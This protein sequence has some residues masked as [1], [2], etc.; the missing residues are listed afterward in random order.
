MGRAGCGG[1]SANKLVGKVVD[2]VG[3]E[4]NKVE[5]SNETVHFGLGD[6][7]YA[8]ACTHGIIVTA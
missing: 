4:S 1:H 3:Y 7:V 2:F 8:G 5:P 6:D